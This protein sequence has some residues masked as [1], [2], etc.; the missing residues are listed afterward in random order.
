MAIIT[1][2]NNSL[3]SVTALP[4]AVDVG[5]MVKLQSTTISSAT[6]SV[7]WNSTY[8]TS[9]YDVYKILVTN[10]IP[11]SNAKD[12]QVGLSTDNL[13][14]VGNIDQR[15]S[16]SRFI[17]NDGGTQVTSTGDF[18]QVGVDYTHVSDDVGNGTGYSFN[19]EFTF[20]QPSGG[21]YKYWTMVGA[22]GHSND[23]SGFYCVG[24]QIKTTSAV[25]GILMKF[26]ATNIESGIFTLYG[27]NN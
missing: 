3:S 22:N 14:N 19:G 6:A 12:F 25:N 27:V 20:Y 13:S 9:T 23:Y 7:S 16:G 8:I 10:A 5:A 11:S 4:S 21:S 24:S 1:L 2:N 18:D 26:Q 17:I 15:S